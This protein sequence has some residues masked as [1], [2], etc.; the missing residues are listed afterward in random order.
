MEIEES[1]FYR[2]AAVIVK[3]SKQCKLATKS[4]ALLLPSEQKGKWRAEYYENLL[5]RIRNAKTKTNYL[6]SFPYLASELNRLKSQDAEKILNWWGLLLSYKSLDLR[7]T[8]MP[9]DSC[10]IGDEKILLKERSKRFLISTDFSKAA[11]VVK[12]FNTVFARASRNHKEIM[13]KLRKSL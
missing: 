7:F 5:K 8:D 6:F 1:E 12:T 11:E 2:L 4:P 13:E 9:F 3:Q 10:I